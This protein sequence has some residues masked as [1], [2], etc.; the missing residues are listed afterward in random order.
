MLNTN[1]IIVSIIILKLFQLS[2]T[3]GNPPINY[4]PLTFNAPNQ[5]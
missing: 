3:P 1:N 5:Q 4:F 2:S